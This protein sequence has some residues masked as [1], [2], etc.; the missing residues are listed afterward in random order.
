MPDMPLV[1]TAL[2]AAL[3]LATLGG[4]CYEY[5]VVDPVWPQRPELIQPQRGVSHAS[6]SGFRPTRRSS[7][8]S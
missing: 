8:H 6:G 3:A 2:A 1:L 7:C 4:G 5:L